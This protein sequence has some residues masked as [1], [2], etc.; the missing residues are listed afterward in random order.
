MAQKFTKFVEYHSIL[1]CM[2]KFYCTFAPDLKSRL[3]KAKIN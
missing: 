1:F 2:S 3:L